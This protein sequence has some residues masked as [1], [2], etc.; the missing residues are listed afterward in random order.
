MKH[1]ISFDLDQK[2]KKINKTNIVFVIQLDFLRSQ[3]LSKHHFQF[4]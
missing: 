2:F 3:K 1:D 4:S